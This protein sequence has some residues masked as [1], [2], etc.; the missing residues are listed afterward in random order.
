MKLHHYPFSPNAIK[1]LTVLHHLQL[2]FEEV[3]VDLTKG[4]SKSEA[5][6][7]LNPNGMIPTLEDGELKLWES[8]AIMRY[9]VSK[10]GAQGLYPTEL[11]ARIE[12]ER[13]LE[14]N[15]CHFQPAAGTIL[16]ERIAPN[17][18]EGYVTDQAALD[19][20]LIRFEKHAKTLNDHLAHQKF[21][22]G[23]EVTLAD[24]ALA[25][26]IVHKDM[27]Q[28]DVSPYENII[29]WYGRVSSLPSWQKAQPKMPMEA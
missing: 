19:S 20:A 5:F 22:T 25:T 21:V 24:I 10:S 1:V 27:A 15:S 18:F 16:F 2:E 3:I 26:G 6:L 7:S 17:F 23:D 4:E 28:L 12:V 9:L 29:D 14:W 8:Q 11:V 13:W